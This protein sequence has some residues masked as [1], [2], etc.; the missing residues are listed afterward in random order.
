MA[1]VNGIKITLPDGTTFEGVGNLQLQVEETPQ[2]LLSPQGSVVG[3]AQRIFDELGSGDVL[4]TPMATGYIGAAGGSRVFEIAFDQW[5]GNSDSWG[6][7]NDDDP[8][9]E[10]LAVLEN[11]IASASVSSLNPATLEWG[12]YSSTTSRYDPIPV[13]FTQV[14]PSVDFGDGPSIFR[15]RVTCAECIDLT[16]VIDDGG[17]SADFRIT[18]SGESLPRIPIPADTLGPSG[19]GTGRTQ[20]GREVAQSGLVDVNGSS[21]TPTSTAT[22][23][24]PGRVELRGAWRGDGAASIADTFKTDFLA[25]DSV[26]AVDFEAPGRSGPTPLTGT[27]TLGSESA[28]DPLTPQVEDG[29]YG[30]EL[31]LYEK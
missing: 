1:N 15:S 5:E 14:T 26:D 17:V 22:K 3:F 13:V 4:K 7:A 20:Q 28:I 21:S 11:E 31:I 27:Y 23:A 6:P 30:F 29:I 2:Y 18:P 12:P 8:A 9:D 25:D 19:R 16:Q 24:L 10:K